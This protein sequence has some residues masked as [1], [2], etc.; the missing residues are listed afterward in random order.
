MA[1]DVHAHY[2]PRAILQRLATH[3]A[4]Y[5]ILLEKSPPLCLDCLRFSYGLQVRP[6]ES[7]PGLV[8]DEMERI[9]GFLKTGVQ[10]Q[11]LSIW[12][13]IFGY[14]LDP[15]HGTKWH[16]LLNDSLAELCNRRADRFSMLASSALQ[17]PARAARELER[18]M[19]EHNA[20]GA[21]VAANLNG[22]NLG[23]LDLDEFWSCAESLKCP[24]FIHPS[25]PNPAARTSR[26]A[27]NAV[28]HYTYDTTLAAGS[29]IGAGVLDRHPGLNIILAHG[30]GNLP[31]LI[32]R[33][34]CAHE[35][36]DR[37][38]SGDVAAHKPSHYLRRFFYDT[39][40]HNP[41]SLRFLANFVKVDR[42]LLGSD[43]PFPVADVD[44][45]RILHR[46]GLSEQEIQQITVDNPQKLF[47]LL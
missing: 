43:D 17:D 37:K 6:I 34:D 28:V 22:T 2:I 41:E 38:A 12:P 25:Q 36:M 30:G 19:K 35:M 15:D 45:V 20:V 7:F 39:L 31:F 16:A 11:I 5:G 1:I 29:L 33:F 3:A 40:V 18:C 8:Q 46:A 9:D 42:L 13:D 32:G 23:D 4:D 47:G 27:L 26:F 10:R 44:P 21:V 14:G 24:V